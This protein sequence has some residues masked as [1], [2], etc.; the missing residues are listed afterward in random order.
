M[1]HIRLRNQNTSLSQV[2]LYDIRKGDDVHS[3]VT[4]YSI[5]TELQSNPP[6]LI[7]ITIEVL[8][9]AYL[10]PSVP[11]RAT[12][13]HKEPHMMHHVVG[14]LRAG[15]QLANPRLADSSLISCL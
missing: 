2:L 5:L 13:C 15:E 7:I 11:S 10:C 4:E 3:S 6:S 9:F 8:T 12:P 14:M 1:R